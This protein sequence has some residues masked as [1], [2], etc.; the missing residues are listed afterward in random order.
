MP[1]GWKKR[2]N[3]KNWVVYDKSGQNS[4]EE[5]E[6]VNYGDSNWKV[7]IDDHKGEREVKTFKSKPQAMAFARSYMR[8][9]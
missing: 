3:E 4:F 2:R 1:S 8:N 6:V 5:V 9:H 7:V